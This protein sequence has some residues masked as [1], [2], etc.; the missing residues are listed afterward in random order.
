MNGR[1][2]NELK[3]QNESLLILEKLPKYVLNWY[4]NMVAS[5]M[6][7]SSCKDYVMK[8]YR[9]LSY[10]N[11]NVI[12]IKTEDITEDIVQKYMISIRTKKTKAGIVETSDSYRHTIWYCLNNFLGYLCSHGLIE[13]NYMI[14][15]K[16]G[17]NNDL[18][19]INQN[20]ILLT[21]K[22]FKRIICAAKTYE[23]NN[24]LGRQSVTFSERDVAIIEL[25]MTTGMRESALANINI[26]D[27]NFNDMSLT[28]I[29]KG[30]IM[31][32]CFM[33]DELATTISN[34]I[35][36]REY[37]V[38]D[39]NIKT[40]ALFISEKGNRISTDAIYD[41]IK[42][43]TK[44]ALGKE[45]SPHKLRAGFISILYKKTKDIE[46]C[47]RAVGHSNIATTQRYITT[48]N[49]EKEE[50]MNIMTSLIG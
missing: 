26:D 15:I 49:K 29:D 50:S 11:N 30:D 14:N 9:F 45:L 22:E 18:Q 20:R 41:M 42:K 46:F 25:F 12:N 40:N 10:I 43:Y 23:I 3:I 38:E 13:K 2:E 35:D 21:E 16:K 36:E 37:Y 7:A 4:Y 34:W 48:S 5:D 1:L 19:R 47:R 8:V 24:K 33:S 31:H 39:K 28:I 44:I 6:S 17:K 27:I 32:K